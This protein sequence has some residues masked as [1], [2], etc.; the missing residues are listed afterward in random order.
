MLI[1]S[2]DQIFSIPPRIFLSKRQF[3]NLSALM[4]STSAERLVRAGVSQR[5][6]C[7]E[8]EEIVSRIMGFNWI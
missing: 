3:P 2:W 1:L 4:G 6:W 8:D 5:G 7:W